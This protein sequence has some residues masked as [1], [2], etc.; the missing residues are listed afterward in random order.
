MTKFHHSLF[1]NFTDLIDMNTRVQNTPMKNNPAKAKSIAVDQKK[2]VKK[3]ALSAMITLSVLVGLFWVQNTR[4]EEKIAL[5]QNPVIQQDAALFIKDLAERALSILGNENFAKEDREQ[6]FRHMLE[7]GFNI[8][9]IGKL[10]LG[11][12]RK[13]ASKDQLKQYYSLFPEY[14]VKSYATRMGKLETKE[15]KIGKV[16]A[17]G[18]KDM[19]VRT[20]VINQENKSYDVDWRV[21]PYDNNVFKIIDVK[22]E[23]ISMTRT[24][25][26]D[27]TARVS[28]SGVKGLNLYMKAIIDGKIEPEILESSKDSSTQK[29]VQNNP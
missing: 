9:Y 13:S 21:R 17:N 24:Q 29:T 6:Q 28:N 11:R 20:K 15:I 19:Y 25:R 26:D 4:A 5:N 10:S 22:I 2:I 3:I 23:G 27:F 1:D 16:I 14:I 8:K 18:K 7:E 12:H